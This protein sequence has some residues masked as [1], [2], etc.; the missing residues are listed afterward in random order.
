LPTYKSESMVKQV[1]GKFVIVMDL[2]SGQIKKNLLNR[3]G[4]KGNTDPTY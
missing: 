2:E 4:Y 1:K 3:R